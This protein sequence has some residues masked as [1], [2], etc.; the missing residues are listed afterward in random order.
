MS[1][2]RVVLHPVGG[3][4][5]GWLFGSGRRTN[6][7][8]FGAGL[9]TVWLVFVFGWLQDSTGRRPVVSPS[10]GQ[11]WV[12]GSPQ[13]GQTVGGAGVRVR[14][15]GPGFSVGDAL[16]R[17][18][19][20]SV[21]VGGGG[22]SRVAHGEVRRDRFGVERIRVGSGGAEESKRS[23]LIHEFACGSGGCRRRD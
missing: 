9:L 7:G 21:G 19:V 4:D 8:V 12:A 6:L 5:R 1:V 11:R 15:A 14:S 23:L 16:G 10:S 13:A 2:L 3:G 18:S 22:W 17:V 20:S